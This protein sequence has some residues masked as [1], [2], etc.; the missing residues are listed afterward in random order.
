[1]TRPLTRRELL[2]RAALGGAALTL[3]GFLAAC[4]GGDGIEGTA[5]TATGGASTTGSKELADKLTMSNWTLYIDIDEKT[6][7]Y[8]TLQQFTKKTGVDVDYIEDVN[9]NDEWFGKNQAALSKGQPIGRD[10]TVLTDWMAGRMV[11]LGYVE[12]LDKEAIPNSS[13]LVSALSSPGWDPNREYSLP[14]Q[15]G[16]TGIGYDPGKVGKELTSISQ[17]LDDPKLKGKVTFL[18][19][20]P[21]T[22]GLMILDGGGD[23]T[24]VVKADFDKAIDRLQKGVDSG[25]IRQ[26]TGNDYSGPLAK[27][28]IWA[29]VAWSG[30]MVQLTADNPNLKFVIPEAGGMIWTDNML[31]PK[32]G[33]V[34]TASTFMNFVYDPKIAAQIE[35]YVN[36]ICP[37]EGA[38]EEI[39]AIDASLASNQLIFPNAETLAKVKIFDADAADNK[40]YKQKF[41]AV[42]GA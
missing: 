28:D 40:A 34:F 21:D 35:A 32:G 36:Y 23:P 25:Q 33:D 27:G 17:L 31:I 20:M 2:E 16:L 14:W 5:T 4:G 29:C 19:E 39:K 7:K 12:K 9:D 1:M 6:K 38:A 41:Q 24:K 11:R 30:D 42:I 10:I 37:V 22:M 18:T 13:N 3:P 8:P 15:S 26:F